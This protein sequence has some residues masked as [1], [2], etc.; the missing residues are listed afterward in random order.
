MTSLLIG[1]QEESLFLLH[2]QPPT[3]LQQ[4]ESLDGIKSI[5]H[6]LSASTSLTSTT[7]PNLAQ[8]SLRPS[9]SSH[10]VIPP[11]VRFSSNQS[12]YS[13]SNEVDSFVR[14]F[15]RRLDEHR[16]LLQKDY[17]RKIQQMI[18]SKNNEFDSLKLRY[19]NKLHELEE[20]NRQ[21]EIQSGQIVEENK[22]LKIELEHKK[23]Q[24]KIELTS[25]QQH[26]KESETDTER[27]LHELKI[28]HET[29]KQEMKRLHSRT[30]QDLL[31]E[32]NQRLKKME[33]EYKYQQSNNESTIEEMEKRMIDLR[34]NI[35]HLQQLKQKLDDEKIQLIKTNEKLQLQVQDLTNKQR[36][37]DRDHADKS[38]R[39]EN[40]LKSVRTRCQSS[41]DLLEKENDMIKTKSSKTID[42]LEKKLL[43]ITEKFHELEIIFEKKTFEQQETFHKNFKQCEHEYEKK[44]QLINEEHRE[45]LEKELQRQKNQMQ[46]NLENQMQEM[47]DQARENEQQLIEKIKMEYE[48]LLQQNEALLR[49]NF[50]KELEET[51]RRYEQ[52]IGKKDEK[53][54]TDLQDMSKLSGE[55][56]VKYE[57]EKQ[58]IINEY[59][60]F[61][62]KLEKQFSQRADE[63]ENRIESL[64]STTNK[65]LKSI[66]DE[67]EVRN[68]KQESMINEQ[69]KLIA[70]LEDEKIHSKILHEKQT[71]IFNE[72]HLRE[73]NEMKSVS[74]LLHLSESSLS[75]INS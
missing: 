27:K 30:Y 47:N 20:S 50:N 53:M 65:Q 74:I 59:D 57:N 60:E 10:E 31:D 37:L 19:E 48:Q 43:T 46:I 69:Q 21:L 38:Q 42:E 62:R 22:R 34:S 71:K 68:D 23:Q 14:Q 75:M 51:K 7:L 41:I 70:K 73:K 6:L 9:T 8:Y 63:Y 16:H 26:S 35:E 61:I 56:K 13:N 72:Q 40:E 12:R 36:Y 3:I 55:V 11:P 15:E 52:T 44:I 33:N 66:E 64:I 4:S 18:E 17:D 32:T 67:F 1:E 58:K 2:E 45:Q 49:T 24:H 28:F 54:K 5:Q 25:L 29:E 39:Y